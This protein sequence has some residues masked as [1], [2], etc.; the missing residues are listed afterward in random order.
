VWCGRTTVG[1]VCGRDVCGSCCVF[2]SI[3]LGCLS[4]CFGLDILDLMFARVASS[5]FIFPRTLLLSI[6]F[7]ISLQLV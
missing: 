5:Q 1:P 3:L 4:S 6:A 7:L 2:H